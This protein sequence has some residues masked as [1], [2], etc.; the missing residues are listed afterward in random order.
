MI[1]DYKAGGGNSAIV[2]DSTISTNSA[3]FGGGIAQQTGSLILTNS[4]V[5]GNTAK[6]SG[7]G[8]LIGPVN[9]DTP[10]PAAENPRDFI[11]SVTISGNAA[12]VGAG[13]LVVGPGTATVVNSI[14]ARDAGGV[15]FVATPGAGGA[16]ITSSGHNLIGDAS[17]AAVFTAAGDQNNVD[18]K[19]GPLADN[20]GPTFTQ[21]L[22]PGS[23]ALGAGDPNSVQFATDQRGLPRTVNSKIDIGAFE[24]QPATGTSPNLSVTGTATK[25]VTVGNDITYTLTVP[26]TGQG[27]A[28]G[29][30]LTDTLPAG[31]TFKSA[32]LGQTP[33]T[34][35]STANGVVTLP[36]G[37]LAAGATDT[38]TI[39]ATP[40]TTGTLSNSVS[41]KSSESSAG[42]TPVT[43]DTVVTA[44]ALTTTNTTLSSTPN[45]SNLHQDVTFTADVTTPVLVAGGVQ[46]TNG[47]VVIF[48]VDGSPQSAVPIHVVNGRG[49]A[50]YHTS[51]L[52]AGTHT[53]VASYTGT[54]EYAPSTSKPLTQTVKA[55]TA[56]SV[57]PVVRAVVGRSVFL[58]VTLAVPAGTTGVPTGKIALSIDGKALPALPLGPGLTAQFSLVGLAGGTH[59]YT[60][61]YAGDTA[62][63]ASQATPGSFTVAPAATRTT[64]TASPT[65]SA[66]GHP[67]TFTADVVPASPPIVI[68]SSA[69]GHARAQAVHARQ[70]V[71]PAGFPPFTGSVTFVDGTTVLGTAPVRADGSAVLTTTSL[72]PGRH[73]ITA[74]FGHDP[75][76]ASS[77]SA[78]VTEVVTGAV[79]GPRVVGVRRY[80]Y[81]RTPTT[82]VVVFDAPLDAGAAQTASNYRITD[83]RGA[84]I[85][86]TS[87]VYNASVGTVTLSPLTSLDLHRRYT[88]T[89][90]GSKPNAVKG[91]AGNLLDG[92]GTGR[93]GSDF[94]TPVDAANLV[95]TN[96]FASG[97]T[98]ALQYAA[99]VRAADARAGHRRN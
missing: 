97:A 42:T 8:V 98:A 88:L 57:A 56:L 2:N 92:A 84:V 73:V 5:N 83:S 37:N 86:V 89:V 82:L 15:D 64:L 43:Q 45:P 76:Y 87:A 53:V 18:P 51:S 72:A 28:T 85:P 65:Q 49:Q 29:V 17:G 99:R 50:T 69:H 96:P 75:S 81:H 27:G 14:V 30:V 11:A 32:A 20:G 16:G 4:T 70:T 25:T 79:A 35:S 47:E 26:N 13:L 23:P 74:V 62:F 67:V 21:A 58:D 91:V 78:P 59:R 33:I 39:L 55:A 77:T 19:L 95:V 38:V 94:V 93:T 66:A 63:G 36:L 22:L 90:N 61:S 6:I 40:S 34:P 3:Q 80:G 12:P 71:L 9:L 7:G 1:L 68:S 24:T 41:V 48:T 52:P 46:Q 10:A 44:Y 54:A 60:A 31:L